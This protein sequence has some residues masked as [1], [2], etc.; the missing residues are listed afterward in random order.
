VGIPAF[1]FP[2][3]AARALGALC[4]YREWRDRPLPALELLAVDRAKAAALLDQTRAAGQG[5]LDEL[6]A[7]ALLE[8]YGIP[9]AGAALARSEDAAVALA[10]R[11]GYP[12]VLKIV[13]PA[14]VHKTEVGGVQVGIGNAEEARGAYRQILAGARRAQP[15]AIINGVLVQR[16]LSGGRELIA[17][18]VRDPSIGPMVMF[19]LGGILVEVLGDVI[20]RLAPI[21][22][23]DA[24][25]MVHGIR[26][27]RLLQGVRGAPPADLRA[28]EDVLLRVS[29]LAEDFPAIAE[30]DVNPLLAFGDGAVA[31]DARVVLG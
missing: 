24:G 31:V 23:L 2:E 15:D 6:A 29:R 20:F 7:L 11:M 22:R 13:A 8:A 5:R 12:V 9:T 17:G 14:I 16:M 10:D 4:R 19:G 27:V 18:L 3:S 21:H 26:G 1:I 28:L 30:L 25:D